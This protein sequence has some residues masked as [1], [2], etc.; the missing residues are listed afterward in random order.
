MKLHAMKS[1]VDDPVELAA[2]MSQVDELAHTVK[3]LSAELR[4]AELDDLGLVAAVRWFLTRQM[5][6]T[7]HGITFDANI[8]FGNLPLAVTTACFRVIQEAVTNAIDH[9]EC[10]ALT[11]RLYNEGGALC[12][13]VSDDGHGLDK[14]RHT[15]EKPSDAGLSL[16]L[17]RER[18]E[19]LGGAFKIES[20]TNQGT[21]VIASF[22]L[23]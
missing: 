16:I 18:V 22:P 12:I 14:R 1:A 5:Q 21:T 6:R 17:M 15:T 20:E 4:P 23:P 9:A 3:N 2:C 7:G 10:N 13:A 11:V 8:D 19:Q